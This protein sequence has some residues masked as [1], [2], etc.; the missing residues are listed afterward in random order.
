MAEKHLKKCITYLVIREIQIKTTLRFHLT[1]ITEWLRSKTQETAEVG[2]DVEKEEHSSIAGRI[3]NLYN[4]SG[5]PSNSSSEKERVL[6]ED[7]V[8]HS[9]AYTAKMLHHTTN[10]DFHSSLTCNSHKLKAT[11]MSL[12]QIMDTENVVHLHNTILFSY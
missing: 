8:Y 11:Q 5:N 2:E 4:H 7:L 10:H 6:P 12:N 3:A 9:W 1:S